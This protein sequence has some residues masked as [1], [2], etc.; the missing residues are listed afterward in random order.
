MWRAGNCIRGVWLKITR[1]SLNWTG[2]CSNLLP[3]YQYPSAMEWA[4]WETVT[5]DIYFVSLPYLWHHT[6]K[7]KPQWSKTTLRKQTSKRKRTSTPWTICNFEQFWTTLLPLRAALQPTSTQAPLIYTTECVGDHT[8][9]YFA[10]WGWCPALEH[11]L[12]RG[13]LSTT[14]MY[15]P[16]WSVHWLNPDQFPDH[17]LTY[18]WPIMHPPTYTHRSSLITV[19]NT[20]NHNNW[21]WDIQVPLTGFFFFFFSGSRMAG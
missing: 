18:S 11:L 2:S 3:S 20:S 5:I 1:Q 6:P 12:I 17:S 13:N 16:C 8:I 19:F 10:K 21:N 4:K 7:I 14:L 15:L 9:W